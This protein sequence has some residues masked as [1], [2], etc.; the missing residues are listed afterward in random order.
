MKDKIKEALSHREKKLIQDNN[1]VKAAVLVPIYLKKGEYYI[2]LI[3]RTTHVKYHKGQIA[4]PG[5][6]FDTADKDLRETALRESAE[7]I[8]LQAEDIEILGELDD[9][10]TM[11]SGYAVSPFVAFF[12][13]PYPFKINANEI[14]DLIE[15][16]IPALLDPKS[17][18]E[19]TYTMD[20]QVLR[21]YFYQ[22]RGQVIWGATARILNQLL[23]V[24]LQVMHIPD[25]K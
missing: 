21:G 9:V 12:T 23:E 24:L 13:W 22:Y 19:E 17:L 18:Q 8:G 5:G 1:L 7:E 16:P 14:D 6:A 15:V 20:G 10:R 2:L 11:G 25:S 3:K 4:F